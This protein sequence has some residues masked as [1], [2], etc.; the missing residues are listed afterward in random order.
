MGR[1]GDLLELI[2]GAPRGVHTLTGSV[3]KWTH[4]ERV[5]RGIEAITRPHGGSVAIARF[6]EPTGESSDEHWRVWLALPHRWR[7]ESEQQVDL[8]N[9][10]RR[11]VGSASRITELSDDRTELEDT[12]IGKLVSSGSRLLG[13]LRFGDPSDDEVAGRSCLQ[14]RATLH[15]SGGARRFNP[16]DIRLGAAD[17][18]FWFDAMTGVALRH[19]ALVDGEPCTITEFKELRINP[20]LDDVDFQFVAP[21]GAIVEGQVDHLLRLAEQR[22]ADLTGVDRDDLQAVQAAIQQ[23]MRP[24]RP[25]PAV[26]LHLQMVK[27]VPLGDPPADEAAAREEIVRAFDHLGDVD[28]AGVSLVNV[29]SGRGLVGP[30]REAQKRVPGAAD[31]PAR[32][33]VDDVK[34]LRPDEAVVWFSVEVNGA[35]FPMVDGREGRAVKIGDRWLIEH[36]TIADLLSFGGATVPAPEE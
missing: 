25:T 32:L 12:E 22:G 11:W 1:K 15:G 10:A 34:F 18:I 5:Q 6:G 21:P 27:H 4:H 14:V 8:R 3:W 17:H 35:R 9:G 13:A 24:D 36:A 29:Q 31:E 30:L 16:L 7:F 33:I 20:P 28:D 2:D 19:V 26:R 23:V